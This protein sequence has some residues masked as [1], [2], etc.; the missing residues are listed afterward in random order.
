MSAAATALGAR[1]VDSISLSQRRGDGASAAN[2]PLKQQQRREI[3][4]AACHPRR[5]RL[6]SRL[7][8]S[9]ALPSLPSPQAGAGGA[10][11]TDSPLS[12]L[13]CESPGKGSDSAAEDVAAAAAAARGDAAASPPPPTSTSASSSTSEPPA[14]HSDKRA[15]YL[16]AAKPKM[17]AVSLIPV[18][19]GAAAAFASGGGSAG[20][21]ASAAAAT[22]AA[23]TKST[24][25]L[26]PASALFSA[27]ASA[28]LAFSAKA[29]AGS[30]LV[31][32]WLNLSN[33]AFD[34]STGVDELGGGKPESVVALVAGGRAWP[35]H[36]VALCCLASGALLLASAL[37]YNVSPATLTP[38]W[39]SG[40]V[41]GAG[42]KIS[43]VA[44]SVSATAASAVS[45][46]AG[47]VA[48]SVAATAGAEAL[49]PPPP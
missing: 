34:S 44:G 38:A 11:P 12:E 29:L 22:A 2:W 19:V 40:A 9:T 41:A 24:A 4:F 46:A 27:L 18:V 17:Y 8:F 13:V 36:A 33:D 31:I 14:W 43:S 3:P 7:S 10:C 30:C 25:A 42:G 15:L 21:T 37:G 23:T 32:A 35:V 48:S 26:V 49:P 39:L 28:S 1:A 47:A 20:A 5:H 45:D 16:A 6:S